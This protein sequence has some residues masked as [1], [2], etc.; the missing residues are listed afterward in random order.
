MRIGICC[1]MGQLADA[2]A[3]GYAY[4]EMSLQAALIAEK[5]EA[6]FAE[7]RKA[8]LA[9]P[10]P[11]EAYNCFVPGHIKVTGPDVDWD[12]VRGYMA[13]AVRRTAETNVGI[14]VFGSGGARRAP[15]G[16]P[17]ETARQQYQDA[18][19]IAGDFGAQH[20]VTI[21]L[22]PL[23]HVQCNI[24]NLVC[25][26]AAFIDRLQHPH[27]KLLTDL[28]HFEVGGEPLEN[29][30]HAGAR[31][32]HVHLATPAIPETGEGKA[33]DFPG[34]IAALRQAGYDGRMSVE[35]NPGLLGGHGD[36][37]PQ[38]IAAVRAYVEAQL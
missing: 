30:V 34:F 10:L 29:I 4:A 12:Q 17:L 32:G 26:G 31:F 6:E 1:G 16:F 33:Y 36:N 38:V 19:K 2:K 35:D 7:N 8:I 14:I 3:A 22:E 23:T 25:E 18:V 20:G 28:Y 27:V 15:D 21:V 24:F 5:P 13:T 11:V 37:F 9:S